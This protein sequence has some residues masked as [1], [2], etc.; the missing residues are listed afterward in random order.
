MRR[1]LEKVSAV[2]MGCLLSAQV[3]SADIFPEDM[4]LFAPPTVVGGDELSLQTLAA[5]LS[6][7]ESRVGELLDRYQRIQVVQRWGEQSPR[8]RIFDAMA[9]NHV[10]GPSCIHFYQSDY[11]AAVLPHIGQ[12]VEVARTAISGLHGRLSSLQGRVTAMERGLARPES[13]LLD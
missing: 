3:A 6:R 7:A 11:A 1:S 13:A 5:E 9:A 10:H 12:D 2:F 8:V 4:N